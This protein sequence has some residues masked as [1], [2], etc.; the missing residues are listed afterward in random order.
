[1]T[2]NKKAFLEYFI[3]LL[4]E[5]IFITDEQTTLGGNAADLN[6]IHKSY[7]YLMAA[8]VDDILEHRAKEAK[9]KED[10]ERDA[11]VKEIERAVKAGIDYQK[12]K[13]MLSKSK[14]THSQRSNSRS[15]HSKQ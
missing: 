3:L 1:M 5:I 9:V 11:K 14:K 4:L 8:Y 13:L 12:K 10:K 6:T 15:K 2:P 7:E